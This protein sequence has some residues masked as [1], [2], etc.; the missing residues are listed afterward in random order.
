MLVDGVEIPASNY[1]YTAQVGGTAG[2]GFGA[3]DRGH[4]PD[5]KVWYL[6]ALDYIVKVL[7]VAST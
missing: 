3:G 6:L 4:S 1:T 7:R 5:Q 2:A